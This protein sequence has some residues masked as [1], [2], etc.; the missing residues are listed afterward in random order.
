[1]RKI[2]LLLIVLTF[3]SCSMNKRVEKD[4]ITLADNTV[5]DLREELGDQINHDVDF[6]DDVKPQDAIITALEKD[7]VFIERARK[8]ASTHFSKKLS[9]KQYTVQKFD[10]LMLISYKIYGNYSRWR[11]LKELNKV[12]ASM[13]S[14]GYVLRFIAPKSKFN[15]ISAGLPYV[16]RRDDTLGKISYKLYETRSKWKDIYENNRSLIRDPNQIFAGFTLF[17]LPAESRL[18]ASK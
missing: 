7:S 2:G 18:P 4:N 3:C 9:I 16:I 14:E 12:D 15:H 17:Y 5:I 6:P 10:T 13:L 1:M 11:E 8:F